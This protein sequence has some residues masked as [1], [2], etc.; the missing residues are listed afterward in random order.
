MSVKDFDAKLVT[1][2]CIDWI[3]EYAVQSD[4][5]KVVI[6][7]SGGKDSYI[8]AA[9]C[10]KAIGSDN[11]IGVLMPNGIQAD[12]NDSIKVCNDLGIKYY[13]VN[14]GS[15]YNAILSS[16]NNSDMSDVSDEAKINIAPRVRMTVLYTIGQTLHARVCGTSNLSERT[17][18]Y[19]TKYGDSACDFNPI[20][21]LT[22]LEVVAI[23]DELGL[24]PEIVH[25]VPDD[26]L[27]GIS[28]EVKLGV[29]YQAIH[30]YIRHWAVSISE[31]STIKSKF[32]ISKHKREEIPMF[33]FKSNK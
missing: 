11:V 12:I 14:I 27:S 28:D 32:N 15:T 33:K 5:H 30:N 26:G 7:I 6:G 4:M 21:E 29:S 19:S 31:Y 22:S 3:K 8:A 13:N 25:K 18:G 16:I 2:E 17:V 23:G 20:G 9:L 1:N 10:C 24:L